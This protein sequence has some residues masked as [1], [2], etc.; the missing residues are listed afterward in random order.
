MD[1]IVVARTADL[2]L[3]LD[4]GQG[5]ARDATGDSHTVVRVVATAVPDQDL[6]LVHGIR[7]AR[8]G[9]R[10]KTRRF[11]SSSFEPSLQKSKDMG[12]SMHKVS[13]SESRLM[14]DTAS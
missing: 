12:K 1:V 3:V 7:A 4:H 13:K 5:P 10:T 14:R 11:R 6:F 8:M 2:F 9:D